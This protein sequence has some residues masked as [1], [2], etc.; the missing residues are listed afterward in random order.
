MKTV[1]TV[2][3]I[4]STASAATLPDAYFPLLQAGAKMV[5]QRLNTEPADL[6]SIEK[7]ARWRHFGYAIL[8]PAVLYAKQ[9]KQNPSYRDPRMLALALRI[10]DLL[11]AESERGVFGPRLDSDWDTYIWLEAY[12]LLQ[13]QLGEARSGRWR[14]EI[15]KYIAHYE[16][17]ARDRLDFPWY[18]SPYIG[19][20][21]NHYSL[22][23]ANFVLGGRVF[24]NRGWQELGA[25]ILHR[26]AAEE[27]TEDGFWGEHSR[28][29]PTPGYNHLTLSAVALYA[30]YSHDEAAIAA[31]RRATTFHENFTFFDGTPADVINDRNRHWAVSAWSQ[32]AFSR[33]PDGRRYAEFLAG[34]FQPDHL[35][36]DALGRLAQDALYYHEGPTAPMPLDRDKFYYKMR[37]GAGMRKNGPWQVCLSAIVDT[38]AVNSQFYLD[39]QAHVSIFHQRLGLIITGA[40]SKRQPE[41]ATFSE[42]L[43]GKPMH[44]P[45]S[46]RLQMSESGDRLSLAYNTFFSDLYI[47]EP[48]DKSVTLRFVIAGKGTPAKDPRLTLQLKLTP[49]ERLETGTDRKIP[50]GAERIE[51]DAAQLGG[52]IRHH[53]WMLQTDPAA[54]LVWPVYPHNPYANKPETSLEHAVAALSVPLVLKAV[55][56]KYVRAKEQEIRF[57]LSTP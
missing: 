49:G 10:G 28:N 56:G 44:M 35:F 20:S 25:K 24:G 4:A 13:P 31:V 46:S 7:E 42:V 14:Q 17:D 30:E 39:R 26:F 48:E 33:F 18:N 43:D 1:L 50:I 12:R 5:E 6:L 21:P 57:T 52:L 38:Q 40:N 41:L 53:G 2:A 22:W 16:Q 51:L 36:M 15:Q 23:A 32:F 45:V 54:R 11:A 34:F 9:H 29:G 55:P 8:P 37:A 3:A 47:P 27:Q 19:T